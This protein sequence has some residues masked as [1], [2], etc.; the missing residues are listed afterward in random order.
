MIK[1]KTNA[2]NGKNYEFQSN[3]WM[4]ENLKHTKSHS[5]RELKSSHNEF[6]VPNQ[7]NSLLC[8][9]FFFTCNIICVLISIN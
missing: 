4:D 2:T 8:F 9:R 3:L 7:Y 6:L 5:I 1:A